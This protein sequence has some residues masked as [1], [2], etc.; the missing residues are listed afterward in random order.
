[1]GYIADTRPCKT[2]H[3]IL[4]RDC[5]E[6]STGVGLQNRCRLGLPEMWT[7]AHIPTGPGLPQKARYGIKDC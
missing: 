7:G 1:M 4:C 6:A 2:G 3:G 5:I